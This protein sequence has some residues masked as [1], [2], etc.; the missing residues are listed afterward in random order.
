[1]ITYPVD[2]IKG[3][4]VKSDPREGEHAFRLMAIHSFTQRTF[5]MFG[6][7]RKGTTLRFINPLLV[8]VIDRFGTK[9]VIYNWIDEDHFSCEPI[10]EL[11]HQFYGWVCGLGE[12]IKI[13]TPEIA[14]RYA[15]YLSRVRSL[16]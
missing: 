2:L 3:V 12:D 14:E 9:G 16:Y 8:T 10:V 1:V 13:D 7:D 4:T 5:G 6:G 11:N 15:N